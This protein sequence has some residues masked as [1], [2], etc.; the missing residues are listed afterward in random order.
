M[1]KVQ[2]VCMNKNIRIYIYKSITDVLLSIP[3]PESP[4]ST[5]TSPPDTSIVSPDEIPESSPTTPDNYE[6]STSQPVQHSTEGNAISTTLE[7]TESNQI[8][9]PTQ[10]TSP[11]PTNAPTP[12]E[13]KEV[14]TTPEPSDDETDMGELA[15]TESTEEESYSSDFL[16]RGSNVTHPACKIPKLDPFHSSIRN[17][18]SEKYSPAKCRKKF[19]LMFEIHI[20][21]ESSTLTQ[22]KSSEKTGWKDCCYKLVFRDPKKSDDDSEM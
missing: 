7:K 20:G 16:T 13:S 18:S 5:E 11:A 12:E 21:N 4:S 10:I 17:I 8:T 15:E 1:I 6:S 22:L 3:T 9:T 14:A 2:L 19:S